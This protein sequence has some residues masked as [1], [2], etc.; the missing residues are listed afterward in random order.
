MQGH[1][2]M[3]MCGCYS[4]RNFLHDMF[5]GIEGEDDGTT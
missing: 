4:R 3:I 2:H 1:M 5:V